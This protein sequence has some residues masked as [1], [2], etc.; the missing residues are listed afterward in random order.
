MD[1]MEFEKLPEACVSGLIRLQKDEST[2]LVFE[3]REQTHRHRHEVFHRA[4]ARLLWI[5]AGS[6]MNAQRIGEFVSARNAVQ[7]LVDTQSQSATF[8]PRGNILMTERG[9]GLG[10][11][12]MSAVVDWL[13][14]HYPDAQVKRGT[15]SEVDATDDNRERRNRFY[16]KHG[17]D[18]VLDGRQANGSFSKARARDLKV[19]EP[20]AEVLA[21][22]GFVRDF[23]KA[24]S[25]AERLA[26]TNEAKEKSLKSL[27]GVMVGERRARFTAYLAVILLI[28]VV[29]LLIVFPS[30]P[31]LLHQLFVSPFTR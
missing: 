15:L 27:Y 11:A 14:Q 8:G 28:I 12:L 6:G 26:R 7:V 30:A 22:D 2:W 16:R 31:E 18:L 17:F 23:A 29:G 20:R 21:L 4:D 19:P 5:E 9:C 10:T 3:F 24:K 1:E 25:D 13:I